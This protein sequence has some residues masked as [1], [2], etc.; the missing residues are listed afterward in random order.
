MHLS[1]ETLSFLAGFAEST[2]GRLYRQVLEGR[3][4]EVDKTLRV[5][6]GEDLYRAQGKAQALEE[7]VKQLDEARDRLN[8]SSAARS[9]GT[10][11]VTSN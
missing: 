1:H 10:R 11:R 4:G 6:N 7:L 2:Q 8:R 9:Q 3:L 5:L